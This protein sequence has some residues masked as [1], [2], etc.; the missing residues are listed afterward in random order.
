MGAFFGLTIS[1]LIKG[2]C[3][4]F[5]FLIPYSKQDKIAN[6]KIKQYLEPEL[7]LLVNFSPD[8]DFTISQNGRIRFT[9]WMSDTTDPFIAMYDD[10]ITVRPDNDI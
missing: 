3:F 7:P 5:T 9:F 8:F 4:S 2:G 10:T 6:S 1:E